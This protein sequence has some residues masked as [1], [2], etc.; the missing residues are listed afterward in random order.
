MR[1]LFLI[2]VLLLAV[3]LTVKFDW[4]T[5]AKL[6]FENLFYKQ[7]IQR[8]GSFHILVEVTNP[9]IERAGLT[10]ESI[11]ETVARMLEKSGVGI[12][13]EELW[14]KTPGRPSLNIW[15]NALPVEG[16]LGIYQYMI[17][18]A[19]TRKEDDEGAPALQQKDKV[20]WST[21]ELGKDDVKAIHNEIMLLTEKFLKAR[22]GG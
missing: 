13:P 1:K 20:I 5:T 7:D 18:I 6:G 15:I 16:Q 22:T 9:E 12:I 4:L 10:R 11:R 17:N 14:Q 2:L 8:I 19:V 21:S 3:F